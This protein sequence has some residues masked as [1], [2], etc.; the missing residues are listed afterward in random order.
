MIFS[1]AQRRKKTVIRS[2][3]FYHMTKT[4][5]YKS[6]FFFIHKY[7]T[8]VSLYTCEKIVP[9][10]N[11]KQKPPYISCKLK[12]HFLTNHTLLHWLS[13]HR[14]DLHDDVE[15]W[16]YENVD[17]NIQG[18][19]IMDYKN[20]DI[21]SLSSVMYWWSALYEIKNRPNAITIV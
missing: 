4:K 12:L 7:P 11:K 9:N 8:T 13:Q 1:Y 5:Q 21:L 17:L 20:L 2:V 15:M 10:K 16:T 19:A 18:F 14:Q 3:I 6:I